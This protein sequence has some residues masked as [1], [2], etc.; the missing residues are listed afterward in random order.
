M[1]FFRPGTIFVQYGTFFAH[2]LTPRTRRTTT[3]LLLAPLSRARGQKSEWPYWSAL[4]MQTRINGEIIIGK[5]SMAW[6]MSFRVSSVLTLRAKREGKSKKWIHDLTASQ[7]PCKIRANTI[8]QI[9]Q[10]LELF[11][12]VAGSFM[13]LLALKS[14]FDISTW[15]GQFYLANRHHTANRWCFR[16]GL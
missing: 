15:S 10:T 4:S 14:I 16:K 3:K 1:Y 9:L 8:F 5:C 13:L 7:L 2:D 6:D 12:D 11:L